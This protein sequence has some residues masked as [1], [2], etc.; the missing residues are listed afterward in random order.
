MNYLTKKCKTITLKML[1]VLKECGQLKE[2]R[3]MMHEQNGNINKV[4]N[5][6][7]RVQENQWGK[8][9]ICGN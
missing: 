4:R 8:P 5:C 3:K 6:D 9:Q 7:S 1:T 2:I